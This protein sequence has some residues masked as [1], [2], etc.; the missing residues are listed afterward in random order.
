MIL[1]STVANTIMS[2]KKL[3][4]YLLPDLDPW[5][6]TFMKGYVNKNNKVKGGYG[7]LFVQKLMTYYG[8][9][10]TKATNKGHDRIITSTI[11]DLTK[12]IKKI[13]TEFKVEIKFGAAHRNPKNKG[14]VIPGVFSFNHF[15]INKDWDRAIIIGVDPGPTVYAVWFTKKDL[16]TKLSSED[17]IFSKQQGGKKGNNDDWMFITN[18]T[19]WQNFINLPWVKSLD[20]W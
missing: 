5:V 9:T 19:S 10:V 4:D 6:D 18:P 14:T 11:L 8:H 3:T 2:D 17:T 20:Q 16:I 13:T 7:E 12:E 15:G 1:D